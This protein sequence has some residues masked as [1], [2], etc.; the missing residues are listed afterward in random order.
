VNTHALAVIAVLGLTASVTTGL[1]LATGIGW[2]AALLAALGTTL[3]VA[4][5]LLQLHRN[6]GDQRDTARPE[7]G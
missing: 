1:S 2:P 6:R 7:L 3:T 4:R 5:L